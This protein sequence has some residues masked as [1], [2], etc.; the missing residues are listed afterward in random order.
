VTKADTG[1][2]DR[3]LPLPPGACDCHVHVF[4]DPARFPFA[5]ERAYTPVRA[6][7][8]DLVAHLKGCGLS[9]AVIVQPTPYGFDNSCTLAAI[10]A[11]GPRF[12]GVAVVDPDDAQVDLD[13]LHGAGVR[14]VRLNLRTTG[15]NDGAEAV[16]AIQALAA[17]IARLGWHVQIF[18]GFAT[19]VHIARAGLGHAFEVPLVFDHF[20]GAPAGTD[21]RGEDWSAV[22][23]LVRRGQAYVK[24]SAPHRVERGD[25]GPADRLARTLIAA[26]PQRVLWGSDWPHTSSSPRL[27]ENVDKVEPFEA[28]DDAAALM[29]LRSW[30]GDAETLNIV[31]VINPAQLY[32]FPSGATA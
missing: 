24:V 28:I 32:D 7:T 10:E 14:G 18:S 19:T 29:R 23:K 1:S 21:P 9:R 13:A 12:R 2:T 25:L 4:G 22:V 20:A 30:C 31:L 17:R 27:P 3:D 5:P 11:L 8:D 15:R 6:E 26:N 16:A